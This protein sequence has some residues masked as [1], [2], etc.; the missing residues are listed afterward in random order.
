MKLEAR[1][2]HVTFAKAVAF[3]AL[4]LVSISGIAIAFYTSSLEKKLKYLE[5]RLDLEE[6][7][8]ARWKRQ[9]EKALEQLERE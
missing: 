9:A 2:S 7:E 5:K 4:S 6:Y 1:N 3:A 8:A